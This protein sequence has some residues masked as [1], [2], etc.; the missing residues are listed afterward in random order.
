MWAAGAKVL[1][2]IVGQTKAPPELVWTT[3]AWDDTACAEAG[4]VLPAGGAL[5]TVVGVGVV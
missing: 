2:M 4:A 3:Q 5:V 1:G